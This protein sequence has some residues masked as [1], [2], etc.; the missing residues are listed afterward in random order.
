MD[1]T[2]E[3]DAEE[4]EEELDSLLEDMSGAG[5]WVSTASVTLMPL[6]VADSKSTPLSLFRFFAGI[7]EKGLKFFSTVIFIF[8]GAERNQDEMTEEWRFDLFTVVWNEKINQ[9]LVCAVV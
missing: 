6:N 1:E 9:K 3:E 4:E 7:S 8:E 2:L 5:M